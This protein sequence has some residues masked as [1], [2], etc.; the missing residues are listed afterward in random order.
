[1]SLFERFRI[2]PRPDAALRSIVDHLNNMLNTHKEFGSWLPDY[3][4][5]DFNAHRSRER[6]IERLIEE[7]KESVEQHEPR[8]KVEKIREVDSANAFRVKL[9][10]HCAFLDF[11]KPV[12]ILIDSVYNRV[13]VE[14][15]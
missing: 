14:G 13:Y 9:E 10:V 2:R 8:V 11:E 5:G 4:I 3:G 7:I 1:M 12:F 6:A 15:F